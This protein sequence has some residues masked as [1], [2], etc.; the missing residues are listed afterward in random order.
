MLTCGKFLYT[1]HLK[2]KDIN[3]KHTEIW[4]KFS[5]ETIEQSVEQAEGH[6]TRRHKNDVI[7]VVPLLLDFNFEHITQVILAFL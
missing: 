6:K 3:S 7:D 1:S 4:S 2:D 5:L